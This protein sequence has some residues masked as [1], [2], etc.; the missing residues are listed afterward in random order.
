MPA[1]DTDLSAADWVSIHHPRW[2]DGTFAARLGTERLQPVLDASELVT[3]KPRSMLVEE[4][5]TDTDVFLLLTPSVKVSARNGSNKE[6]IVALRTVGDLIGEMAAA[7]GGPRSATVR[8]CGLTKVVAARVAGTTFMEIVSSDPVAS[9]LLIVMTAERLRAA[10]RR[11][12]DITGFPPAVRIAQLITELLPVH[13]LATGPSAVVGIDLTQ[14]ELG[15]LVG[16]AGATAERA[17]RDLRAEGLVE[18]D[19]RRLI[20]RD[21]E[22]LSRYAARG[23]LT[24]LK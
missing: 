1:A 20:V 24:S 11:R 8:A 22:G 16:V 10:N 7:D 12:V 4:G 2:A 21:L 9:R 14:H 23:R 13:G 5:A 15:T 3:F 18:T 19:G 6:C 17:L